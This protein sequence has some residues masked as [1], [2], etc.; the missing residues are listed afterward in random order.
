MKQT[1]KGF[2]YYI[3]YDFAEKPSLAWSSTATMG[4]ADPDWTLVGPHDFV[5]ECPD[6]FDPRPAQL[7]AI[8]AKERSIRAEFTA[9]I[10]ELQNRKNKL[11]ALEMAHG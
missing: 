2:V 11:L 6:D 5:I 3:K 9:L 8:D 7:K 1:I 4:E 10:T